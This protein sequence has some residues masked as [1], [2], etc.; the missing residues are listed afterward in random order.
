L[1]FY[2]VLLMVLIKYLNTFFFFSDYASIDEEDRSSIFL[3]SFHYLLHLA[4]SIEDFGPCRGYWQFPMER[5]CG[6]LIPLVKSQIHPYANLWNN[7]VL[8][9]RF[10][11]LKYKIEFY[12]HIFPQEEE[13]E[14]ASHRVFSS[15][16][17]DEV[18]E[19]Y[20]PSKKYILT[21]AELKKLKETYSAIYDLNINQFEVM[22]QIVD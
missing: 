11:L 3:I 1:I 8:N 7:L 2:K 4:E 16:L 18:Y 22:L 15:S 19:L 13:K 6:M 21:S 12:E 14:W 10:N 9:E 20:S 5:M 17:Y